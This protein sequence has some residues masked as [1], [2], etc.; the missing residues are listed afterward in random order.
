MFT[1]RDP[2]FTSSFWSEILLLCGVQLCMYRSIHTQIDALYA[3]I[4]KM[5]ENF[6]RCYSALNQKNW[7]KILPA[8]EFAY[9]SAD[10]EDLGMSPFEIDFRRSQ[11]SHVDMFQS[12]DSKIDS[13]NE[14]KKRMREL[15]C[16]AN[17]THEISKERKSAYGARKEQTHH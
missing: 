10:T 4:N 8:A 17:F 3:V 15:L 6:I 5:K 12:Q 2:K 16:D 9:N 13:A 14:F 11:K 1:D 7:D